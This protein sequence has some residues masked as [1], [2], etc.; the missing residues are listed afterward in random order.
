MQN[1]VVFTKRSLKISSDSRQEQVREKAEATLVGSGG[2]CLKQ[3]FHGI[4]AS[5]SCSNSSKMNLVSLSR[6]KEGH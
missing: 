1:K 5:T 2:V 3:L 6:V 4:V